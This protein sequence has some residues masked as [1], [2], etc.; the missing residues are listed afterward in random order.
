MAASA[1]LA[2][3]SVV[4]IPLD[5]LAHNTSVAHCTITGKVDNAPLIDL[6]RFPLWLG[7][8]A[9]GGWGY[10]LAS[11]NAR[12]NPG[13]VMLRFSARSADGPSL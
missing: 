7:W 9:H 10:G 13:D 12:A 8:P 5:V 2:D 3:A 11:K 1:S 6:R 4:I